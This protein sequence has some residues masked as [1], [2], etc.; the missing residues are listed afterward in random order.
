MSHETHRSGI[1]RFFALCI[2][3]IC[4]AQVSA[5]KSSPHYGAGRRIKLN[6]IKTLTFYAGEKT[7][8]RRTSALPQL[9]CQ[10]SA[11]RRYR[12]DAIQCT[13]MSNAQWKC[14]A[15]LPPSIRM[16]RVEVSCEGYDYAEDPYVLKDSC[17]LTYHLLPAYGPDEDFRS[18]YPRSAAGHDWAG[19]L[20]QIL[21]WSVLGYIVYS[22]VRSLRGQA[23]QRDTSGRGSGPGGGGGGGGGWGSGWG[24]NSGPPPPYTKQEYDHSSASASSSSASWRPGFWTGLGVGGVAA[25][26]LNNRNRNRDPYQQVRQPPFSYDTYRARQ[27]DADDDAFGSS[28]AQPSGSF[29]SSTGFG[30]TRNR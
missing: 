9:T 30:G 17:A 22:F 18:H 23:G 19:V 10:G 25:A 1:Y 2:V 4:L 24:N 27:F 11:C 29:R 20:F 5:Y 7:A 14:S 21:F 6:D 16:G 13:S 26:A 15:D 3:V 8:Y 12:P 28:F